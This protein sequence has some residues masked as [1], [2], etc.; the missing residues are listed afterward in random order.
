MISWGCQCVI[1]LYLLD[2]RETSYLIL[3]EICLSLFLSTWKLTKAVKIKAGWENENDVVKG[4]VETE[5]VE[6]A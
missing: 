2:S 6:K 4:E 1:T 5:M 3:F